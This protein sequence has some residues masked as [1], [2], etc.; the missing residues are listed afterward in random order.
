MEEDVPVGQILII[1]VRWA[2]LW[3]L[4]QLRPARLEVIYTNALVPPHGVEALVLSFYRF[5]VVVPAMVVIVVD[6]VVAD[7]VDV[8]VV[9][10]VVF[11]RCPLVA[12]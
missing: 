7:M 4:K 8:A 10:V 3:Q 5:I 11:R 2:L 9:F 12:L 1:I 6:I